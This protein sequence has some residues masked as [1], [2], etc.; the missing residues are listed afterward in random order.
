ML[1]TRIA[2]AV[3]V[4]AL[5]ALTAL[6]VDAATG[7]ADGPGR[8]VAAAPAAAQAAAVTDSMGWS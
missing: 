2:Q 6:G 4:T 1:R 7:Q 3:A 5:A 8:L